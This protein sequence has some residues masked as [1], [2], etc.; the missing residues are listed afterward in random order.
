ME[1][2]LPELGLGVILPRATVRDPRS[3]VMVSA[4][5]SAWVRERAFLVRT[6]TARV[7]VKG[8]WSPRATL[9]D[10]GGKYL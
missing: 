6:T 5:R 4:G 8:G 10:W 9:S 2:G 7:R 3:R 1:L